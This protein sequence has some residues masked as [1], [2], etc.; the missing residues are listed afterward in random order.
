MGDCLND[1][2]M[3]DMKLLEDEMEQATKVIRERKVYKTIT[4]CSYTFSDY[5]PKSQFLFAC[6][7]LDHSE[8]QKFINLGSFGSHLYILWL[9]EG[10]DLVLRGQVFTI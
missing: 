1:L 9:H 3:E 5:V 6:A 7:F 8:I 4:L 2:S 10:V